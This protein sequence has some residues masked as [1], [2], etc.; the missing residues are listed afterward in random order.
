MD[1]ESDGRPP[2]SGSGRGD[3]RME[4]ATLKLGSGEHI[5]MAISIRSHQSR[6]RTPLAACCTTL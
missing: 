3:M 6:L 1:F 5:V 4:V 2:I